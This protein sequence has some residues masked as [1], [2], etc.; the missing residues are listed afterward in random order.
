MALPIGVEELCEDVSSFSETSSDDYS[1]V[2]HNSIKKKER[3]VDEE[4][5]SLSVHIHEK[6]KHAER[7][8]LY[9]EDLFSKTKKFADE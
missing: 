6:N 3:Y 9:I 5:D 8:N 2:T 7:H 1:S 4:S